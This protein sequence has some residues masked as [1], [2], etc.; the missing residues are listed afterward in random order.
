MLINY[1]KKS[2]NSLVKKAQ[3][4]I[5]KIKAGT[6]NIRKTNAYG[7]LSMDMG[8]GKRLVIL[9]PLAMVAYAFN[10]HSDYE[11]FISKRH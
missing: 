4:A 1:P 10:R 5:E 7:Y 6:A 11:K 8:D 3:K 9:E 2:P